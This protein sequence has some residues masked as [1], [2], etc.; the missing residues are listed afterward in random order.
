MT[1]RRLFFTSLF[2]HSQVGL[3][4]FEGAC[5]HACMCVCVC[6]LAH[7]HIY[8]EYS[9]FNNVHRNASD[10]GVYVHICVPVPVCV[11]VCVYV[12]VRMC[13]YM[14]ACVYLYVLGPGY[15][16]S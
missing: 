4:M 14:R 10:H 7:K 9:K 15:V 3:S 16:V 5:V 8:T 2:V 11:S 6:A 1:K 13:V 12:R